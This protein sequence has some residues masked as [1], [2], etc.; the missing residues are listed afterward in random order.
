MK[1]KIKAPEL[2]ANHLLDTL[3]EKLSLKNDAAL[4]HALRVAPPVL[5]KIRHGR[6]PVGAS[7]LIE[8]HEVSDI[9]IKELRSLMGDTGARF[10]EFKQ[11]LAA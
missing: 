7:L 4:S 2:D 1:Q 9:S 11:Q 10:R 5:S 3:I 6:L 8:M